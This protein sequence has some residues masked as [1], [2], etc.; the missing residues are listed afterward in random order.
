MTLRRFEMA[1]WVTPNDSANS[2]CVLHKSSASKIRNLG[3]F[4]LSYQ[5]ASPRHQ[6]HRSWSVETTHDTYVDE[7]TMDVR[8]EPSRLILLPATDTT[9]EGFLKVMQQYL[10]K[11]RIP[12]GNILAWSTDNAA[13]M[14]R[15]SKIVLWIFYVAHQLWPQ[16]FKARGLIQFGFG[17]FAGS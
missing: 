2:S 4:S 1:C 9:G 17:I 12:F 15:N 3:K 10:T 16:Q 7:E 5:N 6:N 13:V 14:L 11:F 8:T